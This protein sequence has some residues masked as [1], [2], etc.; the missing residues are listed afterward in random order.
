M[1]RRWS[2]PGA[3]PAADRC[4]VL[5]QPDPDLDGDLLGV[6]LTR[7]AVGSSTHL[8]GRAH[9]VELEPG[10]DGVVQLALSTAPRQPDTG[11]ESSFP[12]LRLPAGC[13][14]DPLTLIRRNP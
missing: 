13:Q 9:E 3:S 1:Q 12:P 7:T 11:C 5:L 2:P 10:P 14:S 6:R 8:P 4:G